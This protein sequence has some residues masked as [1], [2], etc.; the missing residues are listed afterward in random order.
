MP[1]PLAIPIIA[2]AATLGASGTQ[3]YAQG[4]MNKKNRAFAREMYGRQREDNRNDWNTQ[5]AYNDPTAMVD[6]WKQAGINPYAVLGGSNTPAGAIAR[7]PMDMPEGKVADF[8]SGIQQIAANM[9]NYRLV[10]AQTRKL[11]ADTDATKVNT[12]TEQIKQKYADKLTSEQLG[13][14]TQTKANLELAN[15][16]LQSE[17][18]GVKWDNRIKANSEA[19]QNINMHYIDAE[20]R[21]AM[22]K[23]TQETQKIVKEMEMLD[24]QISKIP[25]EKSEIRSK[26]KGQ[27]QEQGSIMRKIKDTN[28]WSQI[29]NGASDWWEHK[30]SNKDPNKRK[31]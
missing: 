23:T 22:A 14:V 3:A 6:R 31:R 10:Q 17:T 16:K 28:E 2:A 12:A 1:A 18:Q 24:A 19:L 5:N 27:Q 26:I 8:Q 13:V 21:L 30:T 7:T 25:L 9:L 11:D 4:R 20:K 29:F 15:E